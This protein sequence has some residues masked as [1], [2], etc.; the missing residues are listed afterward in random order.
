MLSTAARR[1]SDTSIPRVQAASVKEWPAP[2]A[3]TVSPVS[4]ARLTMAAT[5]SGERGSRIS[6][7]THTWLPAQFRKVDDPILFPAPVRCAHG[8]LGP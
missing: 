4:A 7:G 1:S 5:S 3:F 8:P 2:T 6:W